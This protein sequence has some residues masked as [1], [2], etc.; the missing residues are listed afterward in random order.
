M[1]SERYFMRNPEK[2]GEWVEITKEEA[3][4]NP[5]IWGFE[6]CDGMLYALYKKDF[7]F[8]I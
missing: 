1:E 8:R 6:D 2:P 7:D 5:D 3:F 4:N